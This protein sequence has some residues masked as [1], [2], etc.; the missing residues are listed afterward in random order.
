MDLLMPLGLQ[1][2]F[3]HNFGSLLHEKV[4]VTVGNVEDASVGGIE[5]CTGSFAVDATC[6]IGSLHVSEV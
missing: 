1:V 5:A 3:L 4:V 6:K 2:S